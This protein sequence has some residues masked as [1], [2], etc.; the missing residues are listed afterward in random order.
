MTTC[1]RCIRFEASPS[2]LHTT[3]RQNGLALRS[4]KSAPVHLRILRLGGLD[5]RAAVGTRVAVFLSG[6]ALLRVERRW[7]TSSGDRPSMWVRIERRL[8]WGSA[9][10]AR[11]PP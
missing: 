4:H 11:R 7:E 10:R 2:S 5:V 8:P 3:S 6:L 9:T 1:W